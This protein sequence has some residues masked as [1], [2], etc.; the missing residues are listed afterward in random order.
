M[1][2]E[3]SSYSEMSPTR[4][5]AA[6]ARRSRPRESRERSPTS[7]GPRRAWPAC[8]ATGDERD[9]ARALLQPVYDWFTEGFDT[10]DLKD[11]KA[12]LDE[13]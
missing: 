2:G 13:L 5:S 3:L 12:L 8:S 6:S 4:R 7:C 11:A 9:E 10:Q 1:K